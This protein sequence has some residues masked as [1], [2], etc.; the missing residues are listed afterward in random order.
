[1]KREGFEVARR[2]DGEAA[3][4]QMA[5]FRPDL[6]LLDMMMPKKDGFEVCQA[7]PR[8]RRLAGE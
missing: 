1:M 7:D 3:L 6:V 2:R 5:E 8:Q 4:R